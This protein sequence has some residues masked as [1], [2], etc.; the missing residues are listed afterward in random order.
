MSNTIASRETVKINGQWVKSVRWHD[1][2]MT[3]KS[4][5]LTHVEHEAAR[6][7]PAHAAEI[8]RVYNPA[9]QAAE[10]AAA[11]RVLAQAATSVIKDMARIDPRAGAYAAAI[12][13]GLF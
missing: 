1:T 9:R 13:K 5:V 6:F 8:R 3:P 12:L 11:E 4:V 10:R 7:L 2:R